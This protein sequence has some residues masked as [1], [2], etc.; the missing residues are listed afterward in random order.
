MYRC[1]V[2]LLLGNQDILKF[3]GQILYLT[4]YYIYISIY[5]D[6]S[7]MIELTTMA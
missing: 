3:L 4:Y 5:L 1:K 6:K 7:L 2:F